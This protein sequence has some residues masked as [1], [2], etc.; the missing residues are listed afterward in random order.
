MNS[1]KPRKTRLNG[2][3]NAGTDYCWAMCKSGTPCSRRCQS[4]SPVPYCTD[5]LKRGDD[6]FRTEDHF[7][8]GKILVANFDLPKGYKTVYFGESF[9]LLS[10]NLSFF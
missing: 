5:H 10:G 2:Q 8:A 9:F 3:Q 1:I 7:L 6:A 4:E